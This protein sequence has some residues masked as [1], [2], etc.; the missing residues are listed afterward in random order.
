MFH[1][2]DAAR[3]NQRAECTAG[4]RQHETFGQY[5]ADDAPTTGAN[6][7]ALYVGGLV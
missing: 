1:E 7:A 5:L 4:K 3:S 6:R 2:R